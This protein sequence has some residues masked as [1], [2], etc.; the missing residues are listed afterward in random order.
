MTA[1]VD[2]VSQVQSLLGSTVTL[3]GVP[4]EKIHDRERGRCIGVE[5]GCEEPS[6]T[7]PVPFLR[8]PTSCPGAPLTTTIRADPWQEPGNFVEASASDP[9]LTGCGSL[10]FSPSLSLTPQRQSANSPTAVSVDLKMPQ[11][12]SPNGL[13]ES[14]LRGAT[15][16]L[17]NGLVVNP[18]AADGLQACSEAAEGAVGTEPARPGGQI[19]LHSDAPV[20]CPD[21]SKIG[22]VE[23]V[24]PLLEAPLEGAVYQ[25]EQTHNPFGSLLAFYVVAEGPGVAVKLP[26]KVTA[27]PLTGQLTTTVADA[28]QLPFSNFKLD[29]F[30][31]PRA[32]LRTA[33]CANYA[34]SALL[35]PWSGMPGVSPAMRPFD[36]GENCGGG[37]APSFHAGSASN[38]AG[39]FSPFSVSLA[40]QTRTRN[41]G[42]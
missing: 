38:Q 27:D 12:E 37:F 9:P 19:E 42:R 41:W 4:G 14:D 17:P 13:G 31:G 33:G 20:K 3:W 36:V 30:G 16:A 6:N 23:V 18:S 22:S 28:P 35:T 7:G 32:A 8:L 15:V 1:S 34:A 26:G 39:G 24:S 25:A 11:S 2:N 5:T 29:F 10:D 40:A 21:A